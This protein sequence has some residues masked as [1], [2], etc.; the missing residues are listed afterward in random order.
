MATCTFDYNPFQVGNS[1]DSI[2]VTKI[3]EEMHNNQRFHNDY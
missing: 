3:M 1:S 2:F